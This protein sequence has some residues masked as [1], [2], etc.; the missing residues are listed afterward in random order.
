[1]YNKYDTAYRAQCRN[2]AKLIEN[3]KKVFYNL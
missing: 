1:M 2:L 3:L